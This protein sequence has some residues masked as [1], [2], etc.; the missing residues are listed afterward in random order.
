MTKS[1]DG[2]KIRDQILAEVAAKIKT[3]PSPPT[4]AVV[5]VGDDGILQKYIEMKRKVAEEVG[6]C[7]LPVR[8]S[9]SVTQNEVIEKIR[10]LNNDPK[11]TGIMVQ[12]PLSSGIDKFEVVNAIDQKKDVDGLRF[13]GG[14]PSCFK[15]P[16]IL[17]ILEAIKQS[18]T[19]HSRE[20]GNLLLVGP[21]LRED[22]NNILDCLRDKEVVIVGRG[23]LV[24]WPLYQ[25]LEEA[26]PGLVV[27]DD[28][29]KNLQ[30]ITKEA[31]I[32]IS[33]TGAAGLIKP[34]MISEGVVLIDAGTAEISGQLKGD[35]DPECYKKA[36]FYT[37][38]PGGIGPVTIAM[39]FQNLVST[40]L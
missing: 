21:R 36:S 34:G 17:A 12:I 13:C 28:K 11:I 3:M 38:V 37:P 27:A 32:I 6:A 2:K 33:A 4:I 26:V 15:P 22:D 1:F 14:F 39:L 10:E 9:S 8:F 30:S 19:C 16:V 23:F 18:S 24:G 40:K 35:I 31:D 7:F 25:C 20:D 29:T 5:S